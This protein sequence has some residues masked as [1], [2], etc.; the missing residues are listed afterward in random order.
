[1][2]SLLSVVVLFLPVSCFSRCRHPAAPFFPPGP[3]HPCGPAQEPSSE[4]CGYQD[5]ESITTFE[6]VTLDETG[7]LALKIGGGTMP[8]FACIDVLRDVLAQ[9]GTRVLAPWDTC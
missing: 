8:H 5:P 1:M 4:L 7:A 3:V 6:L 9:P 2:C